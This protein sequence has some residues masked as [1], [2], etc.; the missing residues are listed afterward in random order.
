MSKLYTNLEVLTN[1]RNVKCIDRLLIGL[2]IRF[3]NVVDY[4][5]I[6]NKTILLSYLFVFS[7]LL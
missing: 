3:E 6:V 5:R 2:K 4:G 7:R 1:E